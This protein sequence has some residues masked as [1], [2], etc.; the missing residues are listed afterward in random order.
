MSSSS[1]NSSSNDFQHNQTEIIEVYEENFISEIK[2]ISN[3]IERYPYVG[4]DT[5]F[6]GVV[7]ALPNYTKDFYYQSIKLNVNSLKL[8]QLGIT[9]S[10]VNGNHPKGTHTW[11]FNLSFN[12]NADKI[13]PESLS[14][15][16]NCGINFE[17]IYKNGINYD[18]F[19]EYL[20]TSG[21]FLNEDIHWISFHG[22]FDFAYLLKLLLNDYLPDNEVDFTNQLSLYFPNHYDIR[23]ICKNNDKLT[24]GLNRI[25]QSLQVKRT[26]EIHQAGSDSYVTVN[27]FHKIKANKI[28]D[29]EIFEASR[30][31][32]YG[33]GLGS[34]DNETIQYTKF[35]TNPQFLPQAQP[36]QSESISNGEAIN[37]YQ[38]Q[39][40]WNYQMQMGG[41]SC[42]GDGNNYVNV[43]LG[44]QYGVMVPH[45]QY[46]FNDNRLYEKQMS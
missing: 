23:V 34:D 28:I 26:G 6:P 25:A 44:Y 29:N 42:Y 14:L 39:Q 3:L 13:T 2:R 30:N 33:L 24:G 16:H 27:V 17:T 46:Y 12:I 18:T 22:A 40:A 5:E 21:L 43:N 31:I 20:I 37:N 38:K 19:A 1:T 32:V 35:I 7:Y 36:M 8:I 10:D 11:Q 45:H 41:M 4:I 9:L 15:L